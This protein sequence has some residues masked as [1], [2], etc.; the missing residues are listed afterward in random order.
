V[1]AALVGDTRS[2]AAVAVVY[3]QPEAEIDVWIRG[4]RAMKGGPYPV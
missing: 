1:N 3:D 4:I 2:V